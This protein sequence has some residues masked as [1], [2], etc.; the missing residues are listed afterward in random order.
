MAVV[1]TL[2][3]I[4]VE[5]EL[6][7]LFLIVRFRQIAFFKRTIGQRALARVVNPA[8]QIVVVVF[9]THTAEVRRKCSALLVI[10]F[11]HRMASHAAARLERLFTFDRVARLALRPITSHAGLPAERSDG[12]AIVLIQAGGGHLRAGAPLVWIL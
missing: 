10:A 3:V 2:A 12:F 7:A 4:H 8:D 5:Y 1:G 6:H 9:F 11:A